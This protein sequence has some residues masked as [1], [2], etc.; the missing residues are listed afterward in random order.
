MYR[1]RS[2]RT[3]SARLAVGLL[4]A[5]GKGLVEYGAQFWSDAISVLGEGGTTEGERGSCG[6]LDWILRFGMG[7]L[8][9]AQGPWAGVGTVDSHNSFSLLVF[10][11]AAPSTLIVTI[12]SKATGGPPQLMIVPPAGTNPSPGSQRYLTTLRI[13]RT[14]IHQVHNNT[15]L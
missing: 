13:D 3:A 9:V 6:L 4:L 15:I 2:D 1:T 7:L 10:S 14:A 5:A 8:L 11:A 12:H